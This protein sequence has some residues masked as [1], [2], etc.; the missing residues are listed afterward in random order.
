[1]FTKGVYN[2]SIASSLFSWFLN[3][4]PPSQLSWFWGKFNEIKI[5]P[6]SMRPIMST[7]EC[8]LGVLKKFGC[9]Y[10]GKESKKEWIYVYI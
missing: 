4:P 1:M 5:P 10:M 2:L 7:C 9:T 6:I 8:T 3:I